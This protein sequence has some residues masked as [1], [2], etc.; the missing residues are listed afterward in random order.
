M[1]FL[2]IC[3]ILLD[4]EAGERALYQVVLSKWWDWTR[5][6]S[7]LFWSY[8]QDTQLLSAHDGMQIFVQATLPTTQ[9]RQARRPTPEKAAQLGPKIDKVRLQK[10][11]LPSKVSNLTDSFG[12]PKGDEDIR[13]VYN[14]ASS[15]LNEA[16]WAPA[17]FLPND[18]SAAQ[19]L[20]SY[21]FIVDAGFGEI[22]LNFSTDPA[23][24]PYTGLDLL[25]VRNYL[26][27]P[28]PKGT[29]I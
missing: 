3:A 8:D 21:S 18:D 6:S 12:A 5:G 10:C 13:V 24:Q 2:P 4:P 1:N 27:D 28:P 23:V 19:L 26:R 15:G 20:M 11:I 17:F 22:F 16:L 14:G 7:L 29:R 25:A 9:M